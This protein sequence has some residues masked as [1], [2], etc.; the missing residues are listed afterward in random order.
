MVTPPGDLFVGESWKRCIIGSDV[1]G[2]VDS[3]KVVTRI[4][5]N[6]KFACQGRKELGDLAHAKTLIDATIALSDNFERDRRLTNVLCVDRD[7]A[8]ILSVETLVDV[9]S[10]S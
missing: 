9:I 3:P 10:S 5:G 8:D 7:K 6:I 4:I 2:R 1:T